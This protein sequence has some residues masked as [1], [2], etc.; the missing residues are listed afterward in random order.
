MKLEYFQLAMDF[1]D[2]SRSVDSLDELG[3]SFLK[4]ARQLGFRHYA[5]V[6]CV[7]VGSTPES[8]V[9]LADFPDDWAS[10]TSGD[11]GVQTARILQLS[12]RQN[13]PFNWE[14]ELVVADSDNQPGEIYVLNGV[15]VPI[16][17]AGAFPGAVNIVGIDADIDPAAEHAIHLMSIY[18]HE[19]AL[20]LKS[21][22]G[23]AEHPVVRLTARE[24]QCLEWVAA[25]KTDWEIASILSIAERTVHNHVE[26]AKL[27]LGV[28]TRV[29][30]VVKAFLSSL[31]NHR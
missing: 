27:K 10:T 22:D 13:L 5:C 3:Q 12:P 1:I 30:A 14:H 29:Q 7:E 8:V 2:A 18:L 17:V 6:A 25:G 21:G 20:K 23:T 4:T 26:S 16:H 19:A 15:T 28:H 9:F 24:R 11:S 31:I